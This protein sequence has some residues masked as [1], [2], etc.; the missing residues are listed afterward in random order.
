V[1]GAR[2]W[3]E[4]R[5]RLLRDAARYELANIASAAEDYRGLADAI[6]AAYV[7]GARDTSRALSPA[8]RKLVEERKSCGRQI[9]AACH[10]RNLAIE[11]GAK[12]ESMLDQYDRVLAANWSTMDHTD[13]WRNE[14]PD[15]WEI[16]EK[17]AADLRAARKDARGMAK[18]IG[19]ALDESR[20]GTWAN[21]VERMVAQLSDLDVDLTE[22][23]DGGE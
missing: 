4:V 21:A 19:K 15:V 7:A 22:Y 11:H 12:P 14:A 1:S 10:Y 3:R 20:N 6:K 16:A 13:G 17:A 23:V 2:D 18:A 9:D 8:I 5:A